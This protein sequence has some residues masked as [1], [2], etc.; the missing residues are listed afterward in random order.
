M[1]EHVPDNCFHLVCRRKEAQT[2]RKREK[3]GKHIKGAMESKVE[4]HST[5]LIPGPVNHPIPT[6]TG[7][8]YYHSNLNARGLQRRG[9][10]DLVSHTTAQVSP[11]LPKDTLTV[12]YHATSDYR[13]FTVPYMPK[14]CECLLWYQHACTDC[15]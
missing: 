2:M 11:S 13:G 15:L 6:T 10:P 1:Y 4:V 9:E 12:K 8:P 14:S 5:G 3:S 7:R